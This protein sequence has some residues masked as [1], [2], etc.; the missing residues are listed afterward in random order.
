M[1]VLHKLDT[2]TVAQISGTKLMMIEKHDGHFLNSHDAKAL[3]EL[4]L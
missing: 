1:I 2:V 4:A 3:A